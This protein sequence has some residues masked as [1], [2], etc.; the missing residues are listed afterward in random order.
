ME[1]VDQRIIDY[2]KTCKNGEMTTNGF[3]ASIET[4]SLS[5]KAGKAA[6]QA[7][8]TVGNMLIFTLI[9]KA[10]EW[11]VKEIDNWIH[12]TEKLQ[13]TAKNATE[14]LNKLNSETDSLNRELKTTNERIAEL[15]NKPSLSF[16]EQEEL[17]KLRDASKE[18]ERQISLNETLLS[19]Q[20][21][22]TRD[23]TLKYLNTETSYEQY[24]KWDMSEVENG[25]SRYGTQNVGEIFQGSQLEV[26]EKQLD[27]YEDLL[28]KKKM[29]KTE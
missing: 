26:A 3:N 18:L 14:E 6:L 19:V 16:I 17:E 8:T 27:E 11:T 12:K 29:S 15:E 20:E 13:E 25:N 21:G 23:A 2:A 7:L 10:A 22:K 9:A 24:G 28:A 1:N 4:M 5:A